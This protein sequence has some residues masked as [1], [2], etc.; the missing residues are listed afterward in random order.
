MHA[1]ISYKINKKNRSKHTGTVE[2]YVLVCTQCP[3]TH[4]SMGE[5]KEITR[6]IFIVT[7]HP[8]LPISQE[9]TDAYSI[10]MD[11]LF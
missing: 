9:S 7:S 2:S 10:F 8:M 1:I 6:P 4:R 3:M 5:L 11:D